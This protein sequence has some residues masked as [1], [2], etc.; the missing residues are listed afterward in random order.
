MFNELLCDFD[1]TLTLLG[2]PKI[3]S[4]LLPYIDIFPL[5]FCSMHHNYNFIL[6]LDKNNINRMINNISLSTISYPSLVTTRYRL[7]LSHFVL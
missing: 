5:N 4:R 3:F 7:E 1:N 6:L 2:S